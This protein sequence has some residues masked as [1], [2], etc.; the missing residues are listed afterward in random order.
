MSWAFLEVATNA[1]GCALYGIATKNM[2]AIYLTVTL[3]LKNDFDKYIVKG[4]SAEKMDFL[5]RSHRNRR[6]VAI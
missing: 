4:A 1:E 6:P 2:K 5:G 3:G